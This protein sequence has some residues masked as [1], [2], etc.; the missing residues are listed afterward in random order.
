M[1][2]IQNTEI[3]WESASH[4]SYQDPGVYKKVLLRSGYVNDGHIQMV[5]WARIPAKRSFQSHSHQDMQE[6]FI[7]VSNGLEATVDDV[8]IVL[9][10]GD[11]LIID[12]GEKH[13][14]RNTSD[15][16]GFFISF[17]ITPSPTKTPRVERG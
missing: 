7:I 16:E 11:A 2:H 13:L 15:R 12:W 3:A 10:K 1:K 9:H 8:R 14:I 4:E 6:V 17:G 5:N